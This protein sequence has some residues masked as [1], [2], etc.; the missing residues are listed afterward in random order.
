MSYRLSRRAFLRHSLAGAVSL[1]VFGGD[2]KNWVRQTDY[3]PALVIGSGF[4]G[5]VAALRLAQAGI[6]TLVL[7]RGR[8]W[9]IT[10]A[11]TT[12]AAVEKPDGRAAW[13]STMTA[14]APLEQQL[15]LTPPVIDKYTGVLESIAGDGITV[16]AGAGVGGG[17]LIYTAITV[18]PRRE[19]FT[20]MFPPAVDFETMMT[21]YYPQVYSILQPEPLPADLLATDYYRSTRVNLKQAQQAGLATR[22]VDL[23]VDW[24]IVR[25]EIRGAKVPSLIAGQAYYGVNSGAKKSLDHN[26][27][28]LAEA[29]GRVQILPLHEV[30]SLQEIR[31]LHLYVVSARQLNEQGEVVARR[32]FV[33]QHLF[34]AAGS[35][36]T[37]KLLVKS[38][39]TGGLPRLSPSVGMMWGNNGDFVVVR[40]GLPNTNPGTGGPAGHFLAEDLDNPFGPS[41]LIEVVTPRHLALEPGMATYIGMGLPAPIGQWRYEPSTDQAILHWRLDDP[42]LTSA[43]ASAQQ[44]LS[45]L[46]VRNTT[47]TSHP[48]TGLYTPLLCAHPLGGAVMGEVCDTYGRVNSHPGLYV[49]DGALI[50]GTTGLANPSF[51]IAALAERSLERLLA[52]ELSRARAQ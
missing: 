17:S 34:L 23:A 7:E 46:N 35:A 32:H 15:G 43:L 8:R 1:G 38:R 51:T 49:V 4:G 30:V 48:Q 25:Q 18:A 14:L 41:S 9:P 12:F 33:C 21:V 36:G 29:T 50:P 28:R 44:L 45:T 16:L 5:A 47:P 37:S 22:I 3:S 19:L 6:P 40:E 2:L 27:L 31:P 10:P 26:Y 52:D 39:A 20:R 42:G 11:G 13:L 24:S